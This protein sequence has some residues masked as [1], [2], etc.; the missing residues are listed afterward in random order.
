MFG[1]AFAA[2]IAED[3]VAVGKGTAEFAARYCS[4]PTRRGCPCRA[5]DVHGHLGSQPRKR[6]PGPRH[7]HYTNGH[8]G[9]P[10]VLVIKAAG[11]FWGWEVSGNQIKKVS[12][13]TSSLNGAMGDQ[14]LNSALFFSYS[15]FRQAPH[16]FANV[17][18][19]PSL[20]DNETH[21]HFWVHIWLRNLRNPNISM[22]LQ[23]RR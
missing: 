11:I 23:V 20:T 18:Q 19:C 5:A 8:S 6:Q 12:G 22:R 15:Y 9:L 2:W 10:N 17:Q 4:K 13:K 1:A 7:R 16:H 14:L 21:H 3:Q